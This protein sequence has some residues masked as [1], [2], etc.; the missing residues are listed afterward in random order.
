MGAVDCDA[1]ILID[2]GSR[3]PGA[4]AALVAVA[5]AAS[6]LLGLPVYPAHMSLAEPNLGQA[7]DQAV[8]AGA[9]RV[10]VCPYFLGE[11]MHSTG[12]VPAQVAQAAAGHPGVDIVLTGPLGPDAALADLVARRVRP[13]LR[14]RGQA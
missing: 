6:T 7:M 12:D 13:H 14:P 9:G 4:G 11:G 1:V 8:A 2:H 10:V 5:K 3:R